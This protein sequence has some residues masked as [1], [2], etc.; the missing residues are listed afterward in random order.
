MCTSYTNSITFA[1]QHFTEQIERD[2]QTKKLSKEEERKLVAKSKETAVKLHDLRIL[3]KNEDDYRRAVSECE[4][5]KS[6]I[7]LIFDQKSDF[8]D[9][10]CK[11]HF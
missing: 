6:K 10:R 2:I 1:I 7:A 9:A 4:Q 11:F 3:H 8:G 5:L